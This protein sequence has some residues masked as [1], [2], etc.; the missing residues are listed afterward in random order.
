[1]M[2][3]GQHHPH[4]HIMFSKRIIDD[5]ERNK[6]RAAKAFFLYPARKK[7][8]GSE[9][10]FEEKFKRGAPKARKWCN[11]QYVGEMRADFARIQNAVLEQNGF[12]IRVD[13]RNFG[14]RRR[15]RIR[16]LKIKA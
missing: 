8:D 16:S 3:D 12:S 14:S 15:G 5:V 11:R 1:M 7:K 4:V 10:S 9:P 2:S 6:E 13:H